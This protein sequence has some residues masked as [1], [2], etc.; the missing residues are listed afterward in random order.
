[1]HKLKENLGMFLRIV[2][3]VNFDNLCSLTTIADVVLWVINESNAKVS[4]AIFEQLEIE[5]A[6]LLMSGAKR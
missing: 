4:R 1:M 5:V 2:A 6:Q 3:I